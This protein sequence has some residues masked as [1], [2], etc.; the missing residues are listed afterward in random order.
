MS[1]YD[2]RRRNA[3]SVELEPSYR[4]EPSYKLPASKCKQLM[5]DFLAERLKNYVYNPKECARISKQFSE[6]IRDR[7]QKSELL[8][9]RYKC[10]VYVVIGEKKEQSVRVS[11]LCTWDNNTDSYVTSSFQNESVFCVVT[12]FAVYME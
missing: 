12:L 11:S 2:G 4:M 3:P 5:D 7:A 6:D 9:P 8:P 10:V 1:S